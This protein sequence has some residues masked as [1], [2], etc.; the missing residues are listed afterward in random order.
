MSH[1][2]FVLKHYK[3]NIVYFKF[4]FALYVFLPS[5]TEINTCTKSKFGVTKNVFLAFFYVGS[6]MTFKKGQNV[7]IEISVKRLREPLDLIHL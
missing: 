7:S 4:L 1:S 6:L 3:L 5:I 2:R